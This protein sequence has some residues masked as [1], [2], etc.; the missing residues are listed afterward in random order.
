MCI[1]LDDQ[2]PETT[3]LQRFLTDY[4]KHWRDIGVLLGLKSPALDLVASTHP[5]Q[6]RECFR[7][8][9]EKWLQLNV[10]VTWANLELAIT[11]ANRESLGLQRLTTGKKNR[12][13][14]LS[15]FVG[16]SLRVCM[17]LW[18]SMSVCLCLFVSMYSTYVCV[19]VCG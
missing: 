11:N 18:V 5:M 7:A 12:S 13:V 14:C 4:C 8:T 19:C 16:V 1:V 6:N 2:R 17:R 15:V 9:L 3:D 10:G